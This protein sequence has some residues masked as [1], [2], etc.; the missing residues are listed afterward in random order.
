MK[1]IKKKFENIW[2]IQNNNVL[3]QYINITLMPYYYDKICIGS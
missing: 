3:L 2:M 1:K